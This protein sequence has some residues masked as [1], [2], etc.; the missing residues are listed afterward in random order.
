MIDKGKFKKALEEAE[1]LS[2][3]LTERYC[4]KCVLAPFQSVIVCVDFSPFI[5]TLSPNWFPIVAYHGS[6]LILCVFKIDWLLCCYC[7]IC[8]HCTCERMAIIVSLFFSG[9]QVQVVKQKHQM[10]PNLR[11]VLT[12]YSVAGGML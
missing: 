6:I 5:F 8:T 4:I 1:K 11:S 3:E 2:K 9:M 12:Q 10:L 7:I